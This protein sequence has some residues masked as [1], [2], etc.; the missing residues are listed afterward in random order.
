MAA[1]KQSREQ[2]L[3]EL[4]VLYG[5]R[6]FICS[7]AEGDF[8]LA[9]ERLRRDTVMYAR[10]LKSIRVPRASANSPGLPRVLVRHRGAASSDGQSPLLEK[11]TAQGAIRNCPYCENQPVQ[12]LR[13]ARPVKQLKIGGGV[14]GH[15]MRSAAVRQW[16]AGTITLRLPKCLRASACLRQ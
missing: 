13:C 16:P 9:S 15:A 14:I 12:A 4:F 3:S 11:T 2:L 5:K 8:V 6:S 1:L 10:K 7:G